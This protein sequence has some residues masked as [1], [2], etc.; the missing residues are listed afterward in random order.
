MGGNLA[1]GTSDCGRKF[2]LHGFG[3]V[4]YLDLLVLLE[5]FTSSRFS[6]L[7]ILMSVVNFTIGT[8]FA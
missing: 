4:W 6:A 2:S 8:S 1:Y 5:I 7:H 3:V